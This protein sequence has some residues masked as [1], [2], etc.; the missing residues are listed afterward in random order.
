MAFGRGQAVHLSDQLDT[1]RLE[2]RLGKPIINTLDYRP[3]LDKLQN[4]ETRRFTLT[5]TPVVSKDGKRTPLRTPAGMHQWR[6]ASSPSRSRLDA[7]D[8]L[9]VHATRFNRQG[10][11][12]TFT[13]SNT[14]ER[15]LSPTVTSSPKRCSRVSATARPMDW[16]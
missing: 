3:F 10:R 12:L 2:A 4:G 14:R 8:I 5:A 1:D 15:S 7:L 6:K 9:D 16:V 11:K 13:L